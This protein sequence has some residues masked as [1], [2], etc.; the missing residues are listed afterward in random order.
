[1]Y[2]Q[3]SL[4]V[5]LIILLPGCAKNIRMST[6][7]YA[8]K[9]AIPSGFARN[10]S[11]SVEGSLRVN[12]SKRENELQTKEVAQKLSI[13][14]QDKGYSI[15]QPENADYNI[16]FNYGYDKE[17][18]TNNVLTYIPQ[19]SSKTFEYTQECDGDAQYNEKTHSSGIWAHVPVESTYYRKFLNLYV[20]EAR[21]N[22]KNKQPKVWECKIRN[23]DE[24]FDIR[25]YTD[26]FIVESMK[27][28]GSNTQGTYSTSM[29]SKDKVVTALR[30][31]YNDGCYSTC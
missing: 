25:S 5:S 24:D 10:K 29:S 11:F 20:H 6:T 21:P 14:L 30:T 4:L 15:E 19:E 17:T 16:V 23:C 1:M 12:D 27:W 31:Q 13:A 9:Q 7:A 8:D 2:K 3:Y 28:F 22:R 18:V 26:F